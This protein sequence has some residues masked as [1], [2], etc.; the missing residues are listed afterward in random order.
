MGTVVYMIIFYAF[1]FIPPYQLHKF[2]RASFYMV[3]ATI[4]GMFIWAMVSNKGPGNL[5]SP[6]KSLSAAYVPVASF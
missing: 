5:L 4:I 3:L 6:A 1:L 2:F